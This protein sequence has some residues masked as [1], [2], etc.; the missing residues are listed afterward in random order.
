MAMILF[1]FLKSSLLQQPRTRE[2][3]HQHCH[4]AWDEYNSN[5][6]S[7]SNHP[8]PNKLQVIPMGN[9]YHRVMGKIFSL[10]LRRRSTLPTAAATACPLRYAP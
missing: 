2:N 3:M 5:D 7:V 10:R 1:C 9:A 6:H 4:G 8:L